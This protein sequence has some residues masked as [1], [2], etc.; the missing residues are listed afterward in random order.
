MIDAFKKLYTLLDARG[1][2]GFALL[3][4]LMLF[5]GILEILS[6][7]LVPAYVGLVAYPDRLRGLLPADWRQLDQAQLVLWASLAIVLFFAAKLLINTR[8]ALARV[9]FAQNTALQLSGRLLNAYL[10]APYEY[11]LQHNSAELQRN[12]NSDSVQLAEHVLVPLGDLLGQGVIILSV[13]GVFFFYIPLD[14][15]TVLVGILAV[16]GYAALSQQHRLQREGREVQRLHGQL[17]RNA[18]EALGC[19]KEITLLGRQSFFVTRFRDTFSRLARHQRHIQIM[20]SRLIPGGVELATI[21]ALAGM[22][23]LLFRQQ[24]SSQEVLTLVTVAAV[25]LAR[26]KGSLS[27]FMGAYSL[28][29]HKRAALD[30]IHAD[31][32]RLETPPGTPAEIANRPVFQTELALEDVHYRYPGSEREVLRGVDLV[33]R[34]GEAIGFVGKTGAGKSTLIDL[35]LGLLQPT[36]GRILLDGKELQANLAAWQRRIGYVPQMLSLIDG[37]IRENIALGIDPQEIDEAAMQRAVEQSQLLELVQQLPHGLDTAIGE[38]GIRL[39]GGQRQRIAIARAL[40]HDPEV[41][42]LD[43]GTSALDDDTEAE[44]IRAVETLKG[45]KTVLMIAHRLS[46]LRN[47]DH[48]LEVQNGIAT[49]IRLDSAKAIACPRV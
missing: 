33:I 11:H 14:A 8:I 15:L 38:R 34:R 48:V 44:V 46:T 41:I 49:H 19:A 21:A 45:T 12:L 2:R 40:Y 13:L 6:L 3:V 43:E 18:N 36:A 42:V 20:A 26:L 25:G 17:I 7:H 1:R 32:E 5:D 39:S 23:Y 9:R 24:H 29:H 31:L 10:H 30:T 35:I 47:C 22:I 4:L 28:L 27:S 37:S 16:A